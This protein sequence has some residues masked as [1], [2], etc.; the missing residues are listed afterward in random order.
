MEKLLLHILSRLG[1]TLN[2]MFVSCDVLADNFKDILG[3]D[4]SVQATDENNKTNT[5]HLN[6]T[7]KT[8]GWHTSLLCQYR[9]GESGRTI[10]SVVFENG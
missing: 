10:T 2:R 9:V 1:L 5:F 3:E 4:Y 7:D 6:I 8:D